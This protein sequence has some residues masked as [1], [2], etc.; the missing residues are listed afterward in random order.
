MKTAREILI[1][2]SLIPKG[3]SIHDNSIV[4]FKEAL[5]AME[6]Y[7]EQFKP[8]PFFSPRQEVNDYDLKK[9]YDWLMDETRGKAITHF[10]SGVAR[11]IASEIEF[12]LFSAKPVGENKKYVDH[13]ASQEKKILM[14]ILLV[15]P[16]SGG[17][18]RE[19]GFWTNITQEERDKIEKK[20]ENMKSLNIVVPEGTAYCGSRNAFGKCTGCG[21]ELVGEIHFYLLP[22]PNQMELQIKKDLPEDTSHSQVM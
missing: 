6:E 19:M 20:V 4:L 12:R 3:A 17:T 18:N 2:R 5:E 7:A 11:N 22:A 21:V 15:S 16:A 14:L 9:L 8:K 10:T 1:E 13:I